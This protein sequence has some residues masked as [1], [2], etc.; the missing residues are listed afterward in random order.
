MPELSQIPYW[1]PL[2]VFLL[3]A[4]LVTLLAWPAEKL[5]WVDHPCARK[6]HGHPVPLVGGVAMLV[7]FCVGVLLLPVKPAD[8]QVLLLAMIL[9]TLVGLYDDLHHI[10]PAFRFLFQATVVLLM[11]LAAN[12]KLS[13]LGNLIGFGPI[14][15]GWAEWLFTLFAVIG[16][17]NAFNMI[18]GLDGLAGGVALIATGWLLVLCL[19]APVLASA[20]IG[21]LLVLAMAIAGFLAHNLR[22]PW[23]ARAS[24]FMGDAG[25]TMLGFVLAC[26]LIRMSDHEQAIMDPITAVWIVA[27][28]LMD[29]IAVMIRRMIAGHSPF[30]ADHKHL[31]HLLLGFGL[32]AGRVSALLLT[33]AFVLGG[34]GVLYQWLGVPEHL[35]FYAF[36]CM[37]VLYYFSTAW[38][39]KK[40]QLSLVN[41]W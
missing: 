37:A 35:R 40:N 6:N 17:I 3:S 22:H 31:H 30:A 4:G 2:G 11:G 34:L 8:Y 29:T 25:S 39:Q 15:L 32:S 10:R 24:V 5:G 36:V 28:P 19:T 26:L 33:L 23:R 21:V 20:K 41:V 27:L 9:L 7:A 14:E 16:V 18:D 1:L 12:T 38:M 13:S